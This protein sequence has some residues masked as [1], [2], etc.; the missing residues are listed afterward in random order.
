[1]KH[2]YLTLFFLVALSVYSYGAEVNNKYKSI[3]WF[4]FFYEEAES[5]AGKTVVYRPFYLEASNEE[6]LF[7]ASLMPIFFWRYKHNEKSD[8]TKGF[9]GFYESTDYKHSNGKR[10]YDSGLIPLFLY[11]KGDRERDNYL[12]VYPLGG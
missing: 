10:D 3:N 7:Q 2:V 8:T 1:M 5:A 12:F 6:N 9:F 4:W 11:G